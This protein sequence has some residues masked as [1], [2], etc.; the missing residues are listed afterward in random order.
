M[1]KKTITSYRCVECGALVNSWSGKCPYCS[2]WG[3]LI[4]EQRRI[5]PEK[6]RNIGEM[7]EPLA[8]RDIKPPERVSSGLAELDRVLGGGWVPGSVVLVGGEPGVGKSTLL[9]QACGAMAGQKQDVLYV[10]GEES[11]SQVA[12][13]ATRLG[14]SGDELKILG[15]NDISNALQHAGHGYSL[16]VFDSVQSFS[17]EGISGFPGSPAQVRGV[18]SRI[19]ETAKS[20]NVPAVIVGHITKQG[21]LAGPKLLEHMV[22]AVLLFAGERTSP[23]RLLRSTKN[24]FGATD[25][26]G[27][28]EMR[29]KGLF[30]VA[31][32][33][34]LYWN[35]ESVMAPGVAMGVVLEGA[36]P[37][38]AEIQSL[39][40]PTPF[41]YPKRTARGLELGRLQL[42]LAVLERRCGVS[43]GGFDVYANV[44]GG[45]TLRDPHA[46]LALCMA[47]A[48]AVRDRPLPPD[49]CFIGEVGLAGEIRP[50]GLTPLRIREAKRL[51]FSKVL[52]SPSDEQFP[53]G[54]KILK[55]GHLKDA[56][57]VMSL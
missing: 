40:A 35:G 25:E 20:G 47:L 13:R 54:I 4:E 5:H 38:V 28:F 48:S 27:V 21:S 29:E 55:V 26:L 32:P 9:L 14:A 10:S 37:F 22:D 17:M 36:R 33:S 3:T 44:A 43:S 39:V 23:Y 31:D 18:A 51:G 11:F 24:R 42:M 2:Q 45:F 41:P 46:D 57:E 6:E 34:R 15:E 30:P 53:D 12:L 50:V 7:P 56:L 8:V 16:L 49:C 1:P 19:I 52:V